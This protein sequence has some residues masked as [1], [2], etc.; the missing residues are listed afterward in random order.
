MVGDS[1]LRPTAVQ[2]L[3]EHLQGRAQELHPHP[4]RGPAQRAAAEVPSGL[5][6]NPGVE[7]GRGGPGEDAHAPIK[8]PV[9]VAHLQLDHRPAR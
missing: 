7:Q 2:P 8:D 4:R 3:P 1:L 6:D 5:P 9:P